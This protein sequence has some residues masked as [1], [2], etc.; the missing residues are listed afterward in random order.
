MRVTGD[1]L[2]GEEA[3]VPGAWAGVGIEA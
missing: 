2:S 1:M 3:A